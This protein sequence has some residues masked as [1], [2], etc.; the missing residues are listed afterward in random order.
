M[1]TAGTIQKSDSSS[2]K[3]TATQSDPP[4]EKLIDEIQEFGRDCQKRYN[5]NN[6]WDIV[7]SVLGL[8]LSIAVVGAGFLKAPEISA[9]L[10]AIVGAVLTAQKAFPFGQRASFYR[11]LIGQSANLITRANQGLLDKKHTVDTLTSLRMDFAQQLPRGSNSEPKDP[12]PPAAPV[13]SADQTAG[14]K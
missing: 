13:D 9:V 3:D 14:P 2:P 11:L 10:G 12:T 4:S 1:A 8:L 5:F 6:R 7:L